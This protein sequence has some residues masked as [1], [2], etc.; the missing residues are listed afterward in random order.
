MAETG[1]SKDS[2]VLGSGYLY[3]VE[4]KGELP[5]DLTTLEKKENLLGYIQGGFTLE[6]SA[7][8]YTAKD[9]LGLVQKTIMT[10]ETVVAKSGIMTWN[11]LTLE[12]LVSTARVTEK[13]GI[14]TIKIGGVS[15]QNGK[16][17]VIHFRHPDP[18]DGDIR[19]T[20]VGKN[21]AG[22]SLAFAKDKE[23]VIDAEF[24]ALPC[25]DE[26]TLVLINEYAP[27]AE[28]EPTP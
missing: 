17:Y 10:D 3:V 5:E 2:V 6:Y 26:G 22:F 4:L 7:E 16:D 21:Q 14:R 19:A 9:D 24:N 25:D 23:T 18:Q 28:D 1:R 20:I 15:N 12:K 13:N 11:G 27:S 8:F